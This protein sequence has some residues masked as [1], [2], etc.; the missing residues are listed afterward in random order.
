M[1]S[2]LKPKLEFKGL[3]NQERL[4]KIVEKYLVPKLSE[5]GFF[6]TREVA[7][8]K[9]SIRVME[10]ELSRPLLPHQKFVDQYFERTRGDMVDKIVISRDEFEGRLI[11]HCNWEISYLHYEKW[12]L[13]TFG[14]EPFWYSIYGWS[15]IDEIR[16]AKKFQKKYHSFYVYDLSRFSTHKVMPYFLE[17]IKTNCIPQLEQYKS[18]NDAMVLLESLNDANFYLAMFDYC[19]M[20]TQL[21]KAGSILHWAEKNFKHQDSNWQPNEE[22]QMRVKLLKSRL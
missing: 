7:F 15:D 20:E 1:F 13:K 16:S 3:P 19:L 14:E 21:K 18:I 9:D 22:F 8:G 2:F 11:F 6:W 4:H 10:A 5:L 17:Q 12:H